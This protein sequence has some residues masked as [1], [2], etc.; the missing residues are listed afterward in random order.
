MISIAG[1][2]TEDYSRSLGVEMEKACFMEVLFRV[3]GFEGS[4][5]TTHDV[6]C[7]PRREKAE[8]T[9]LVAT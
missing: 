3:C 6:K 1:R 4:P 5:R 2:F 8:F 9:K 7:D